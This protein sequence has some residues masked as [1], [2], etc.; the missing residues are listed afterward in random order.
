MLDDPVLNNWLLGAKACVVPA[1]AALVAVAAAVKVAAP[2]A[3]LKASEP[4][5]NRTAPLLGL[6]SP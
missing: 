3:S 1:L 4:S 6:A 2:S 5:V